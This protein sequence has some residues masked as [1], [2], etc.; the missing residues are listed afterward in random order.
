MELAIEHNLNADEIYQAVM[1][2]I[3]SNGLD[4]EVHECLVKAVVDGPKQ[5]KDPV[6]AE[7]ISRF[8]AEFEKALQWV[9]EFVH[10]YLKNERKPKLFVKAV[11]E[12]WPTG[13]LTKE[14]LQDIQQAIR[15]RF[16][17]I[18]SSMESD[19]TPDKATLKQ[20]QQMGI[21]GHDV[22][23]A[24]FAINTGA[25]LIRNAFVFGR[26]QS[27]ITQGAVSYEDIIRIASTAPITAADQFAIQIA[28]QQAGAYITGIG[29][30]LAV[31]AAKLAAKTGREIIHDMTVGYH[32]QELSAIKLNDAAADKIVST[33]KGFSSELYHTMQDKTRDWDRVAY[34]EITDTAKQGQAAGLLADLGS[35]QMV[36]KM[37]M[38]TA[39][40]QCRALYL[41]VAGVPKL[42]KLS[43]MISWGNNIGRKPMPVKGGVASGTRPDGDP[44]YKPVVG[45]VHPYCQCQGPFP[46]TGHEWFADQVDK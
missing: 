4:Y 40:P 3:K 33:W 20:W 38:P 39:C 1:A 9:Q 7:M 2:L 41:N 30:D 35:E 37:P 23:A 16:G 27:A 25:H 42:F 17:Y 15:N 34:C 6:I 14:Q 10:D 29:E 36:Y 32:K 24:D 22:T 21:I 12:Q 5:A 18:V 11:G 19:F 8:S 26:M 31:E 46:F 28:E 45:I 44:T 13:P 43:E